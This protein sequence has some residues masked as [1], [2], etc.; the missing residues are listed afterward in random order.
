MSFSDKVKELRKI[1]CRK[2]DKD[3]IFV[4]ND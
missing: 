4:N 2:K 3:A 1:L